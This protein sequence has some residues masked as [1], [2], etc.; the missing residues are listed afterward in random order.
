MQAETD[1]PYGA[2]KLAAEQVLLEHHHS[3]RAPLT[4]FRL[5]NVFGKWSWPNYNSVVAT[6]CHNVA[7]DLPIDVHDPRTVLS[8]VYVD[9]VIAAFLRC[10]DGEP[11][12]LFGRVEP[13]YSVTLGELAAR[14]RE[15][16]SCRETLAI[17]PVGSGLCRALY[18]TYVSY[19]PPELF[20]YDL[21][22]Y[23]DSRG[24]FVEFL[25]PADGGQF[26]FFTAHPGVTRGGHYHHSKTEKFLVT[27][28]QALFKFR[29]LLTGERFEIR[30]TG[31]RPQVVET[32]PG[33]V[34]DI[35]NVGDTEMTVMLWANEVF[36][37]AKPDTYE[38]RV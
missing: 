37:R 30:T 18:A 34:H 20:S 38:S 35:T 36:D 11:A 32:V 21:R 16:R 33:W 19:L 24:R 8:L 23:E 22:K 14:I 13:V 17:G 12:E 1:S 9:D 7:R 29:N 4:I 28:G 6:F 25:K 10:L 27:S 26:S 31:D 3:V 15:F 2:S 5:P